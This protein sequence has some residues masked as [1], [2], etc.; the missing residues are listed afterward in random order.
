[1][2]VTLVTDQ[3]RM[4]GFLVDGF[5]VKP[6]DSR[7]LLETLRAAAIV[8]TPGRPIVVIDSDRERL[9]ALESALRGLGHALVAVDDGAAALPAVADTSPVAVIV[10][11]QMP[12]MDAFK[13]IARIRELP[14]GMSLPILIWT[15]KDLGPE[16]RAR[17]RT[18]AEAVVVQGPEGT[19][20]L[21]E[22][23]RP[24]LAA[25]KEA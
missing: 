20:A 25:R 8:P 11:L 22:E 14:Q 1:V 12:G 9:A 2:V 6:V 19:S 13:L 7:A 24:L 10:D 5:L 3:R 17:L 23:L 4:G 15:D 16:E 18:A 21:I